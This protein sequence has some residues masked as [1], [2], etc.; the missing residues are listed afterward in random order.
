MT[1]S[2]SPSSLSVWQQC[3]LRWWHE[4]VKGGVKRDVTVDLLRGTIGHAA[5]EAY[6]AAEP[7]G[8]SLEM[9]LACA[10]AALKEQGDVDEEDTSRAW[11]QVHNALKN[12]WKTVDVSDSLPAVQVE[13]RREVPLLEG[14][15][16][17]TVIDA[18][19]ETEES[20]LLLEHKFPGSTPWLDTYLWWHDQHR[21]E[22]WSLQ[23]TKPVYIRYILCAPLKTVISP[24]VLILPSAQEEAHAVLLDMAEAASV[25]TEVRAPLPSYGF[26][27]ARCPVR[28]DCLARLTGGENELKA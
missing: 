28:Q 3:R 21:I 27:C 8:R 18:L 11:A 20:V 22:A 4:Y 5:L 13:V 25:Y 16:L 2:I 6:Y 19:Y 1:R 14:F 9:M 17:H 26:H 23:T 12:F 7:R 10:Q 24:D 15:E